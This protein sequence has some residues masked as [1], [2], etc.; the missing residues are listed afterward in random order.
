[1]RRFCAEEEADLPGGGLGRVGA[2]DQVFGELDGQIAADGT[3][4]SL[5]GVGGA[6]QRPDDGVRLG[7]L[8][9]H[10]DGGAPGDEGDQV[11][12]ERLALMLA[13][14][15]T[16]GLL[17]DRLHAHLGDAQPFAFET[18]DDLADEAALDGIGLADHQ[19]AV[20]SRHGRNLM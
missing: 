14:V 10:E 17:A 19:G 6:H 13:V 18:G 16:G 9:H 12:V 4:R 11:V 3:G 8:H 1:M 5:A 2:M 7:A 20:G 15:L